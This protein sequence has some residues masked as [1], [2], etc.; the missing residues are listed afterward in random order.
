MSHQINGRSILKQF[1]SLI[2]IH[3]DNLKDDLSKMKMVIFQFNPDPGLTNSYEISK[4]K[5]ADTSTAQKGKLFGD[6]LGCDVEVIKLPHDTEFKD[7]KKIIATHNKDENVKGIIIQYPIPID[8]NDPQDKSRQIVQ[9]IATS[10]DIDAMSDAGRKRWGRCATA[11]AICRVVDAGLKPECKI[12]VVGSEGFV[13]GGVV[14]YL[15]NK[16]LEAKTID[17]NNQKD[18]D[19]I[20]DFTPSVLVSVTGQKEIITVERLEG[21]NLDLLVDCGFIITDEKDEKGN[22][23]IIGDVDRDARELSQFV[24]PV[25]GGIGP[26]EMAILL[27][28]FMTKEFPNLKIEPWKLITL[29]KLAEELADRSPEDLTAINYLVDHHSSPEQIADDINLANSE[30]QYRP[31]FPDSPD[32]APPASPARNPQR[33]QYRPNTPGAN[34]PAQTT[35]NPNPPAGTQDGAAQDNQRPDQESNRL[36]QALQ[37][38]RNRSVPDYV[39]T[40]RPEHLKQQQLHRPTSKQL[41]EWFQVTSGREREEVAILYKRLERDY[42]ASD[43]MHGKPNPGRIPAVYQSDGVTVSQTDKQR[44]DQMVVD[45]QAAA[46]RL[47]P[48]ISVTIPTQ[49]SDDS[50]PTQPVT[51]PTQSSDDSQPTQPVTIPTQSSDDSQPTQ[52]VT[53]KVNSESQ[54][55]KRDLSSDYG[56][57]M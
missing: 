24:T 21:T 32:S 45:F 38:Q 41:L 51:I 14:G 29:D 25:P 39:N 13:G 49:G 22:N 19:K 20:N 10:K 31:N 33:P 36:E 11:D 37:R 55:R 46:A 7:F 2:E 18:I 8:L 43:V 12:T 50:Q 9:F 40:A 53:I 27:E 17:K 47:S 15:E 56:M 3:R 5:A 26:M 28:R 30:P 1:K 52:P 42:L 34:L 23:I 44:L 48:N 16:G 54:S 6:F 57:S 35:Q 4:Y